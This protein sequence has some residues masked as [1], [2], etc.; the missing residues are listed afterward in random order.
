MNLNLQ[1]FLSQIDIFWLKTGLMYLRCTNSFQNQ[2]P[3]EISI[4]ISIFKEREETK[5]PEGNVMK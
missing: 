5:C 1:A 4:S 2:V 3:I